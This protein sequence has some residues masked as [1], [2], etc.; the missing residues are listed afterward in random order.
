MSK[1]NAIDFFKKVSSD[2]TLEKKIIE[3]KQQWAEAIVQLAKKEGFAISTQDLNEL[4]DRSVEQLSDDE[5]ASAQGG[6]VDYY[7]V[8]YQPPF[9]SSNKPLSDEDANDV[10]GGICTYSDRVTAP[11]LR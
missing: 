9:H 3:I 4:L 7:T 8:P 11:K 2:S 1:E 10:S 6:Y 5:I